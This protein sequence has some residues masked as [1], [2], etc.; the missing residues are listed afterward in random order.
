MPPSNR[1]SPTTE[2]KKRV[3][4]ASLRG[5]DWK[6]VAKHNGMTPI[7][8]W[9]VVTTGRTTPKPRGGFRA[10]LSKVT[11][12]IRAALEGYVDK[13]CHFTLNE[14]RSFIADDFPGTSLS[15]Q[16]ISRHLLGMAYTMKQVRIEPSTCNN[17][18]NKF[19]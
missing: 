5:E 7:T 17:E 11:P 13:N 16:T 8:A 9:R 3:L 12:E 15:I 1:R 18:T 19:K 6:L 10:N 2:E 14:M 4:E